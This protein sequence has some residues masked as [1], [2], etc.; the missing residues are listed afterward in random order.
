MNKSIKNYLLLPGTMPDDYS[1]YNY[2]VLQG[3][4]LVLLLKKLLLLYILLC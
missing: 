3:N 2:Y 4:K 1:N